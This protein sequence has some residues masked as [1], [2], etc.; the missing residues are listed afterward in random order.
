MSALGIGSA[1]AGLDATP[2]GCPAPS[3]RTSCV[4]AAATPREQVDV[5]ALAREPLGD[6]ADVDVHAAGIADARLIDRARC[7]PRAPPRAEFAALMRRCAKAADRR[8]VATRR[9]DL[10]P[11]HGLAASE[12]RRRGVRRERSDLRRASSASS[13]RRTSISAGADG[14]IAAVGDLRPRSRAPAASIARADQA[15][16]RPPSRRRAGSDAASPRCRADLA[17]RR[18][19]ARR[20]SPAVARRPR[21]RGS[22]A[23]RVGRAGRTASPS[24]A[25]ASRGPGTPH[26]STPT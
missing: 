26:P 11:A 1:R 10:E 6:G 7:A 12:H 23:G 13:W 21:G 14:A 22:R 19:R 3:S 15:P 5:D 18:G 2:R 24:P 9:F 8:A 16:R 20:A 4:V 17:R 25:A